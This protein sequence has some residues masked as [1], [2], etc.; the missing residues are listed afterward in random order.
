MRASGV[1]NNKT[2][3]TRCRGS[4]SRWRGATTTKKQSTNTG[5]FVFNSV[6]V[7][8]NCNKLFLSLPPLYMPLWRVSF[9]IEASELFKNPRCEWQSRAHKKSHRVS[10]VYFGRIDDRRHPF[11]LILVRLREEEEKTMNGNMFA[12]CTLTLYDRHRTGLD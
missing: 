10:L 5:R 11:R 12:N 6:L 8:T 9:K 1:S 3:M 4:R 2:R 7:E